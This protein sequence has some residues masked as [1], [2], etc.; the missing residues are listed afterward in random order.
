MGFKTVFY[1]SFIF[2]FISCS[3]ENRPKEVVLYENYC[4]SCHIAPDIQDLPKDIWENFVLPDMAARMGI[5]T[6]ENHP[7][8]KLSFREQ[9]AVIKSGVY[10]SKPIINEKDWEL[11]K[12][13]IIEMAPDSLV[14]NA[15][16]TSG[17]VLNQFNA[18]PVMLDSVEGSLFTFLKIDSINNQI[19]TGNR[20]GELS[21][22]N[23]ATK[24]NKFIGYFDLAITDARIVG[25]SVYVTNMGIMD[26]NEIPRGRSILRNGNS[27]AVLQDSLHRPVHTLYIDLDKNGSEE[28]IISEFGNLRGKL[29]LLEKDSY[30][31][32]KNR[33]LLNLPG[34]IRVI[35]KDMNNDGK[36]DL[37]VMAAQGDEAVYILYQ[38]DNLEFSVEKVIRFSPVY[39]SS[40]FEL[41]DY[42]GDGFDDIITVNGDNADKSFVHKPYHGMRI[43]LNDGENNFKETYFYPLNGATRLIA[44][45][46]DQDGDIDFALL[47]TFPDYEKHPEYNFVYLNNVNSSNYTFK[48]ELLADT[49]MARWFLIDSADIDGD[50]DEDIVL[51]ALTYSFTPVPKELEEA[52]SESYTD[53]LILENKLH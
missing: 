4:A 48:Q 15:N 6:S 40:W 39:G 49:K 14:N 43:H 45:D 19:L 46:F 41:V 18:T 35:P 53:L 1:I 7:Y 33:T 37:V 10:P 42:N 20:K 12:N 13:Y 23:L 29:T 11:L 22:Y 16:E 21:S 9:M 3:S 32:Y 24:E 38:K 52:W 47:A 30:G 36:D 5:I 31:F 26:P 25:D 17:S 8:Y 34:A 2:L 28:I 51:S 27:T 44:K 50:G